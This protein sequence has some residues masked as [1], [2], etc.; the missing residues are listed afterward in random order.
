MEI[1]SLF[2][3][4]EYPFVPFTVCSIWYAQLEK[5]RVAERL[6]TGN[7]QRV[8]RHELTLLIIIIISWCKIAK[9]ILA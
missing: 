8:R 4:F 5:D 7:L 6:K 9:P 1:E 2:K 3:I